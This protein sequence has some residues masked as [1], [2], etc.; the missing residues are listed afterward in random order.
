M[1]HPV[2]FRA[3]ASVA[4]ASLLLVTSGEAQVPSRPPPR[5]GDKTKAA[6]TAFVPKFEVLAETRLLM[7]GLAHSNYRGLQRL[8]K[9]KPADHDTWIFARGQALLIAETG[10]LLLLRPPRNSGRDTWM[11][12][13]MDLRGQAGN[14]ARQLAARDHVR[15]QVGMDSLAASCNRCHTMFRVPVKIGTEAEKGERD[16]E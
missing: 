15:A 9:N 7:E 6:P 11:K 16:T 4:L 12:L 5:P 8:L 1:I 3:G 14:L 13:A 10:N 2:I